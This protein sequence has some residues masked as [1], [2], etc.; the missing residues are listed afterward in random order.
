MKT[1]PFY[2]GQRV[3]CQSQTY[4]RWNGMVGTISNI[5]EGFHGALHHIVLN[6][7]AFGRNEIELGQ[8]D[9]RKFTEATK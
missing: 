7:R 6:K 9:I 3:V 8:G 4:P 5:V 2:I 1:T